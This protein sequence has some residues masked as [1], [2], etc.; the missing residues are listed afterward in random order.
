MN[1]LGRREANAPDGLEEDRLRTVVKLF[2]GPLSDEGEDALA[3]GS[4]EERST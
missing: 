2:K 1:N 4:V 3:L